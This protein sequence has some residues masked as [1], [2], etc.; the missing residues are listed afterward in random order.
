MAD[1][2]AEYRSGVVYGLQLAADLLERTDLTQ[3]AGIRYDGTETD[4]ILKDGIADFVDFIAELYA[5]ALT[6]M[7]D[8]IAKQP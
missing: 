3:I 8:K 4:R 2:S 6:E 5:G 1:E 7:A